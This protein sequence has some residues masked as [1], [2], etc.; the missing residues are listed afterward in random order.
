MT[1]WVVDAILFDL[2][3]TLVDSAG[4]VERSWR[5]LADKIGRPWPE[6]RPHIHG[7]PVAQV[8]AMLEPDMSPERVDELR[9]FMIESESTDT[10]GVVAL[11]SAARVLAALPPDRVAIVTSCGTRLAS[12][13]IAAAGLPTPGVVVTADDVTVGKPDPAP[14]LMGAKLLGFPPQ[15]CLV[16]E[17]APA[18][19]AS[20]K[21]AGSPVIGVLTTHPALDAPTV[22]TLG[23]IAFASVADGIEVSIQDSTGEGIDG[24]DGAVDLAAT[25]IS[26]D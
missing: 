3:G 17:D 19:V 14:Y 23:E 16:V 1:T 26:A 24:M 20:A 8:M 15:R 22:R 9:L 25:E 18:G 6:V 12:A 10:E 7:V 21:A 13:R 11:P 4:S 2:D 5:Q